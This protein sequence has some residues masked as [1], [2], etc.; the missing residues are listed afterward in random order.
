MLTACVRSVAC[1]KNFCIVNTFEYVYAG[2]DLLY[3]DFDC[4]LLMLTK[5]IEYV[6][7]T[8]LVRSISI[9]HQCSSSCVFK[10]TVS[11]MLVE[12]EA[13]ESHRIIFEHDWSND[14]FCLNNYCM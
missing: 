5:D 13:I 14:M 6:D 12:R 7:P 2:T 1:S 11:R 3:N 10:E 9:V 8:S 4:P